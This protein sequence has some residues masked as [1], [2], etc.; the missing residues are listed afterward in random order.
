MR[1]I[2]ERGKNLGILE[3]S[4]ALRFAQERNLDLIEIVPTAQPPVCKIMD[5]GK[6]RY[7]RVKEERERNKK[8]KETQLKG[9]RIGFT[10][11]KHDLVLRAKQTQRF[12]E[13][14]NKVRIEMRL[15][16]REKAHRELALRKFNEFLEMIPA[17]ILLEASPK[18][19]PQGFVAV[20]A[21]K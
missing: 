14:G 12:L 6:F 3:I 8:Q 19:L 2:D 4:E 5:F 20:I 18:K 10:T 9:V 16:G 15:S 7:E 17:D 13:E 1:V 21:K 11:G